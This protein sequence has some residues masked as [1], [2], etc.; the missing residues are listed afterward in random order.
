[1]KL[2]SLKVTSVDGIEATIICDGSQGGQEDYYSVVSI[3]GYIENK[4]IYGVD[5]VQSFSLGWA[6]IET[7]TSD[8]RIVEEADTKIRGASWRIE[9]L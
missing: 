9:S 7:L 2:I 4:K 8:R 5:P 3:K 6:M 1:M